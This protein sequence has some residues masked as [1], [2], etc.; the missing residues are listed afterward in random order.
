MSKE[1]FAFAWG[2]LRRKVKN[3]CLMIRRRR[4]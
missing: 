2:S 4:Y 3:Q 1:T